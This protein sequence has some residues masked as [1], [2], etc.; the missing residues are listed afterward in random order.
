MG[1]LSSPLAQTRKEIQK[2]IQYLL[3]NR[4]KSNNRLKKKNYKA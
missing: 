1:E 3:S 2:K 4:N